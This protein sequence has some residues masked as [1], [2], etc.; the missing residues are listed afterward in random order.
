MEPGGYLR[1]IVAGVGRHVRSITSVRLLILPT[2]VAAALLGPAQ[3][4]AAA[5]PSYYPS[6]QWLPAASQNFDTGRGGAAVTYIIIHAT[7]GS[8]EGAVSWFR[9]RRARASAHYVVRASDGQITQLVA[10]SD[11]AFHARGFNRTGIGIEHE[12][13]PSHGIGYTDTQYQASASV[14]C[15]IGRRYG[16]PLD[17]SH[18]LGHSELPNT[19]HTDPGPTWDWAQYMALVRSCGGGVPAPA[20][21]SGGAETAGICTDQGCRPEAG[22]AAGASGPAVTLLQWDLVYLGLLRPSDVVNGGGRFG[23]RTAGALRAYQER[24]GLPATGF[25]GELTSAALGRSLSTAPVRSP[26]G[27]LATGMSSNDVRRLQ[28]LLTKSGYMD[29]I[30]G[31]FGAVTR[32]AVKQFQ[33]D[34]GIAPTGTYGALTRMALAATR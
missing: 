5:P 19:D 18:I 4:A 1:R 8:Y 3:P 24:S 9:D 12:F 2:M 6:V 21:T 33:S 30:T 27:V 22:L 31:Y 32:D 15:A 11:T 23:S 14:V 28:V 29:R 26:S 10:E 16:I 7:A 34:H 25:Y 13:D 17:R 20:A